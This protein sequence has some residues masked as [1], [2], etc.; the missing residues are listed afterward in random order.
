MSTHVSC[1]LLRLDNC[2]QPFSSSFSRPHSLRPSLHYLLPVTSLIGFEVSLSLTA[3]I[4][5]SKQMAKASGSSSQG[6]LFNL[7]FRC[8]AGSLMQSDKSAGRCSVSFS[9]SI[10]STDYL[11]VMTSVHKKETAA[12]HHYLV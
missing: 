5:C 8:L 9:L 3:A 10:T 11:R 12:L 2:P 7:H 4:R 1:S 6:R